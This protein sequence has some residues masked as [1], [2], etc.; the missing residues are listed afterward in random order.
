MC[1]VVW[2]GV[3]CVGREHVPTYSVAADGAR[4][5]IFL[6]PPPASEGY[7]CMLQLLIHAHACFPADAFADAH[8]SDSGG[9][10]DTLIHIRFVPLL[11]SLEEGAQ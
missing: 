1:G 3:A 9:T 11:L 4:L 7:D 5:V 8:T 6:L 10:Q 2:C